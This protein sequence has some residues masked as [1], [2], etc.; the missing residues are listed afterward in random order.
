MDWAESAT[1]DQFS[2]P[3]IGFMSDYPPDLRNG[4]LLFVT[5]VL[6]TVFFFSGIVAGLFSASPGKAAAGVKYLRSDG[7]PCTPK[8]FL[9]R[10]AAHVVLASLVLLPGPVLGFVFGPAADLGSVA[11]LLAAL[12]LVWIAVQ[13]DRASRNMTVL[14]TWLGMYPV[15]RDT[16]GEG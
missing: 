8:D 11:S 15:R 1:G 10:G 3:M 12:F 2:W 6:G 4:Y 5:A 9:T 13:R 7:R 14:N 16:I